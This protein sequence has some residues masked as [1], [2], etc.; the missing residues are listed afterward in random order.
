MDDPEPYQQLIVSSIVNPFTIET[1]INLIVII[2]LLACSAL[3][4]ASEVALFSLKPSEIDEISK[5]EKNSTH[6]KILELINKPNYLLATILIANNTVNIAIVLLSTFTLE[7]QF[8]F[9]NIPEWLTFSIQVVGITFLILLFGEILPK[10]YATKNALK[11]SEFVTKPI[12]LLVKLFKPVSYLLISS[13]QIIDKRVKRKAHD[14]SVEELSHAIDLTNDIA[15]NEQ[16]HQI[17][18]GIVKFGATSVI[19]I[20]TARVNVVAI[21]KNTPIEDV[22]KTINESG[23]SRIPVF[24][25]TFDKIIGV[26]YVKDL[27]PYINKQTNFDWTSLLRAPFFIPETKKIDLLLKEFQERKIHLAI[28]VDE[29]GGTSG[30]ISFE[31]IIE[32]IVGEISDE[33]DTEDI[34]YSKL[35]DKTYVFDGSTTIN[36][37]AKIINSV[38]E[39]V[40][41]EMKKEAETLA[42]LIIELSGKIPQKN[43][44]INFQN[45]SFIIEASDKRRVKRVKL[46]IN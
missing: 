8:N 2:L 1:L 22:I 25:E 33:F 24:E 16:E 40:F 45:L 13:T 32:E 21:E 43:E 10:V 5:S 39:N 29:Y 14:I 34:I 36:D 11:V 3:I 28:I 26:L 19:E 18:K 46:I 4:S 41:A 15:V 31:D 42:G 7:S 30:I 6:S 27:I 38:D 44:K 17:L 9:E 37:L 35:D 12:R 23:H 20:M